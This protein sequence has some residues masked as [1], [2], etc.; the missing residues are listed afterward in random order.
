MVSMWVSGEARVMVAKPGFGTGFSYPN[1]RHVAHLDGAFG[2]LSF[3]QEIGQ[4]ARDGAPGKATLVVRDLARAAGK[5]V[6]AP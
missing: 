6:D 2:D 1:V 3:A 5:S 4:A